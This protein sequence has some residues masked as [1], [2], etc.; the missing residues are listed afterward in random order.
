VPGADQ[1]P[2]FDPL[3]AP[4]FVWR[5]WGAPPLTAESDVPHVL[6]SGNTAL[7]VTTAYSLLSLLP[8][9]PL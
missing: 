9:L 6:R 5:L 8:L 1:D 4:V 2:R 7:S 3:H